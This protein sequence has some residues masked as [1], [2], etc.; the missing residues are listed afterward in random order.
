[1]ASVEGLGSNA[2]PASP[3]VGQCWIVGD[4]PTGEWADSAQALAVWTE[5]G[6]RF[7][8]ATEGMRVWLKPSQLCTTYRSSGWTVGEE[9]VSALLVDG[10][11]VVGSRKASVPAPSGGSIIDLEARAAISQIVSRLAAHGLIEATP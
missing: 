7:V 5:G 11:A 8:A 10:V 3:D 1:M 6:W 4:A 2:P 9:R